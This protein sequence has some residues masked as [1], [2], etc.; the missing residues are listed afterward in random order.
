QV[1]AIFTDE[2]ALSFARQQV[3]ERLL[4]AG[5]NLPDGVQPQIGPVTTGLGEVVMYTVG[6]KN[7]DGKG[8]KKVAGQ[9]GWQPD[10][11]YLTPE[12]DILTDEIAKSGYLRTV[13][14]WIV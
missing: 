5:E 12:G 1:T 3:G 7:P 11:S 9:P 14:D 4:Q 8:A 10:G 6:Y 2:T 13:Q